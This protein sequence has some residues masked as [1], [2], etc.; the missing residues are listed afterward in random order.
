M[1]IDRLDERHK[2]V[3]SGLHADGYREPTNQA[4]QAQT[5]AYDPTAWL[6]D[7]FRYHPPRP[8]QIQKYAAIRSAAKHLAEVISQNTPSCEDQNRAITLLRQSVH[9]ANAA[10]A[11]DGR[12]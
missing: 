5:V 12:Y 11:L 10:I 2:E 7:I 9:M 1:A 3:H 6:N 4:G 8:D